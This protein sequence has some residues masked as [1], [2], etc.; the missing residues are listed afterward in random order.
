LERELEHP[1]DYGFYC[2]ELTVAITLEAKHDLSRQDNESIVTSVGL[3]DPDPGTFSVSVNDGT[4]EASIIW[5][6]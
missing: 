1:C 4:G 5:P 6:L 2:V 3:P